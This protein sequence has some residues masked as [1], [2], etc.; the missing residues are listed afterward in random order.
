MKTLLISR[1]TVSIVIPLHNEEGNVAPL[2]ADLREAMADGPDYE[3]VLVD[4]GSTDSTQ[5]VCL[6]LAADDHR[7]RVIA[8]RQ[9]YGQ[10]AAIHSGVQA[11]RAQIITT[12]D[13]DGQ[14]PPEN[15]PRLVAPLLASGRPPRLALIAGQ[16][17]GRRDSLGKRLA[18][19]FANGLRSRVLR[20]GTRDTGCGLKAFDRAAYLALPF[21]NH[22][23]RYLP[24]LFARDGWEVAHQD[25]TH[26]ARL[27]GES[28]YTNLGRAI[29]G[30]SD[31][32]G[33]AWLIRRRKLGTPTELTPALIQRETA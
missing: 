32:A 2:I 17:V 13:G 12:M 22:Q 28:N 16:R 24:A 15:I 21:F 11:A 25:V 6:G 20:D 23:H 1:P 7:L 33:V 14:N 3:V 30:I 9:A 8:H 4:D 18:S 29:V 31:L 5:S 26:A 10:S 19:R 27:T